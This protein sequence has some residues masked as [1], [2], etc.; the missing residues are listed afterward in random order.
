MRNVFVITLLSILFSG[1]AVNAQIVLQGNISTDTT[2]EQS[3]EYLLRGAVFV[4]SMVTLTIEPGVTIFGEKATTGTLIISRGAMIMALGTAD[5]PIVFTS[6]QESPNR[7]DWGGL[8]INGNAPINT[9]DQAEGEGNTGFYGG[10]DPNDNSGTLRYV[11][12]QYAGIEFSADNELNGIAF[13]GVG[14]GTTVEYCQVHMNQD[15]GIEFFGGTVDAKYLLCTNIRDDNF[16]WTDGWVGRGQFWVCQQR[17]D[18]ADNGI[19]A[20]NNG[21]NNDLLPRSNPTIYNVTFIGDPLGEVFNESDT[22]MLL[23][24]GTAGTIRNGIVMGF[25]TSGLDVDQTATHD[26]ANSGDL[27]VQNFIFFDNRVDSLVPGN[28]NLDDD[29]FDEGTWAMTAG[30]NNYEATMVPVLDPYMLQRTSFVSINEAVDGTV[31]VATP[32]NDGFFDTSVDYIGAV[33]PNNVW[34]LY[35]TNT[36]W[37]WDADEN[38]ENGQVMPT[39]FEL[40]ANLPNPFSSVTTIQY[41]LTAPATVDLAVYDI[42]GRLIRSLTS[43]SHTAGTHEVAW[44]GTTDTGHVVNSGIYFYRLVVDEKQQTVRKMV[45][46]K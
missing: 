25:N 6:D 34:T 45:L 46:L 21:E 4:D 23:R 33:G 12:V 20:D 24:E 27:S 42:S 5:N 3:E 7:G 2:L 29:G 1:A 22:G 36:E 40:G 39:Q 10:S 31:P 11:R 26:L 14:N 18:D 37:S 16:D 28:F 8:I 17:G 43:G 19:E 30:F 13:Q 44:D 32:P 9:G 38:P 35:W 15:D 41:S